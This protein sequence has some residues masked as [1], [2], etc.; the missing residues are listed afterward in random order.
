MK[1]VG[2]IA[3]IFLIGAVLGACESAPQTGDELV[4]DPYE[5]FN[6]SMHSVN[7]G[8]DSA[9]LRPASRAYDLV[10]PTL[11][12]HI[13]GNALSNLELPGIFVNQLLQGDAEEAAAT[14]GRFTVNT[15]YGAGG[16]LDPSVHREPLS[17]PLEFE[18][19]T[20]Q[21]IHVG[22]FGTVE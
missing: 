15:I 14:F 21:T 6:R 4:H 20:L 13:F 16:A 3:S 2:R 9:V 17:I 12:R 8:L 22:L 10:T 11:F 1:C 7:K 5:N 18:D 19:L